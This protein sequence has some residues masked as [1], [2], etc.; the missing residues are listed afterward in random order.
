M[1]KA[2]YLNLPYTNAVQC[3][4][5]KHINHMKNRIPHI[6]LTLLLLAAALVCNAQRGADTRKGNYV[7]VDNSILFDE[8]LRVEGQKSVLQLAVA[9]IKNVRIGFIGL[10][11]RGP[12]A[13]DR[14]TY[15]D[16]VTVVALCDIEPDR[17]EA[18]QTKILEAKKLP[19]AAAYTGRDGWRELCERDDIDLV[20]I[21]TNWQ[22][23]VM[24]ATYAMQHG[25][26][27]ALEVPAATTIEECWQL[28]DVA[29]QTQRHCMMLENCCYDFFELTALNMAQQGMFGENATA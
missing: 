13:V 21:C 29:E 15:I 10:G 5:S 24:M 2:R 20:Y 26:H 12:D 8:P 17:V 18:V 9:P 16:G 4:A 22:T 23:H 14:M 28:V 25:K 3:R 6:L 27:V 7:I 19:R 11:M 1:P